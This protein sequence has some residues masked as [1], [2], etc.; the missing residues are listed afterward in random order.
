M[1]PPNAVP[2]VRSIFNRRI[3]ICCFTGF[4]SG[5]PFYVLLNL[6]PA[7]LRT[8]DI[9]LK[10]IGFFTLVQLPYVWKFLWA[11]LLD[12]YSLPFLGRRR[13]WMLLTQLALLASIAALGIW[14]PADQLQTIVVVATLVAVFSATLD[15][16]LDAYRRELLP[17]LELGL[18]N[19]VHV[20]AYRISQ[21]VPGSLGMILYDHF[22][23][24]VVFAV[25]AA[26]VVVG[27]GLTILAPEATAKPNLPTRLSTAIIDP[28]REYWRRRGASYAFAVLA[29]MVLYKLGDN[30]ATALATPFY[31]DL[32]F[33]G[34][35]IGI[36]AK[37][38]GLWS[39]IAGGI[40]GGIAMLKIGINRALWIFGVAQLVPILGFA[41]LAEVGH[42]LLVLGVVVGLEAFGVG[43]GTAAFVAFI[44]RETVP[45]FAA[46][47]IALF[48]ALAAV[49]R[50][51]ANAMTG[52]L[53]EGGDPAALGGFAGGVMSVLMM[54]GLPQ[55]GLGYTRFF[56]LCAVVAIPGMLLLVWVAPW[57]AREAD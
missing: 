39:S 46:T 44:A 14:R 40:L 18:G 27:I 24:S 33:S 9:G 36:V 53:I 34:T 45:A 4:A 32:G 2:I 50:T 31:L 12:R 3:L 17:D 52:F 23:W 49:P 21:L 56:V 16:A 11:P 6:V 7:W 57:R 10:E 35:E 13:S 55:E 51:F 15:I 43:L 42:S 47:Q 22:S 20:Q 37:N 48:T 30:M 1:T 29:F 19:S 8:E 41:V 54:L 5:L 25:M 26:F 38:A 28:F